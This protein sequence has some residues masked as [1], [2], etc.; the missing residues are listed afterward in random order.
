MKFRE[1]DYEY[2]VEFSIRRKVLMKEH[3]CCRRCIFR[4]GHFPRSVAIRVKLLV[5]HLF[6]LYDREIY[7]ILARLQEI[8]TLNNFCTVHR[9]W[10][11]DYEI[12]LWRY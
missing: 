10:C 11:L 5:Q 6:V 2:L 4:Y 9:R 7:G 1:I 3:D 8:I 12:N